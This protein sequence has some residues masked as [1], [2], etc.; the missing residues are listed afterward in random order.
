[1]PLTGILATFNAEVTQCESLIANAHKVDAAGAAFMTPN[2]QR[3]VTVAAFL[4]LFIAWEAFIEASII[5]HMRGQ[6]CVNG[7]QPVKYVS[8]PHD[9][10]ARAMITHTLRYFD[11]GNHDNIR[12]VVMMYFQNGYPYEPHL[13]SIFSDLADLKTIRNACAHITST[14]QRGLDN[15]ALRIF[16]QPAPG[17]GVYQLL[18]SV[19]P[20]PAAAGGTVFVTYKDTLIATAELIANG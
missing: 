15:L 7:R 19:D 17:I 1:L 9:D 14:T 3:Q 5:D 2:D 16:G 12:K 11:Y 13:S 10:A 8:P 6:P 4:N 20:R 18:T